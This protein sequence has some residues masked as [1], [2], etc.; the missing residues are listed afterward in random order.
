MAP[1]A[2]EGLRRLLIAAAALVVCLGPGAA[3]ALCACETCACPADGG[4]R[5]CCTLP[6]AIRAHA[7]KPHGAQVNARQPCC[8][9][10]ARGDANQASTCCETAASETDSQGCSC[11]SKLPEPVPSSAPKG[12]QT[13][14]AGWVAPQ[15]FFAE[16]VQVQDTWSEGW[17]GDFL[18]AAVP[19]RVL[20]CVWR[21]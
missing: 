2:V 7:P 19:R 3:P 16:V 5:C 4:D 11:E 12:Q 9:A 8:G 13:D 18:A 6:L 20:F 1:I 10:A 14:D 15:L 21:N 17:P